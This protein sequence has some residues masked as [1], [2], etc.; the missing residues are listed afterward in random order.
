MI[1]HKNN[2]Q[3]EVARTE[4]LIAEHMRKATDALKEGNRGL[5]R[6]FYLESLMHTSVLQSLQ[7]YHET[8]VDLSD[9]SKKLYCVEKNGSVFTTRKN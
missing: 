4:R 6:M 3:A 9:E 7:V 8:A 2:L 1:T 5:A